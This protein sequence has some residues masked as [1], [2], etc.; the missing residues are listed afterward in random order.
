MSELDEIDRGIVRLMRD[1]GRISNTQIARLLN[2]SEGTIRTRLRRLEET[3]RFRLV[4]L[5]E[6]AAFGLNCMAH[7]LFAIEPRY[8]EP[9]A[10]FL[11]EQ[12]DFIFVS[13]TLSRYNVYG[14]C[15]SKD[16]ASL[17]R[18]ID[19]ELKTRK[20]FIGCKVYEASYSTRFDFHWTL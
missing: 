13:V 1:D 4:T 3:G 15:V 10:E 8:V 14:V 19:S 17:D 2:V 7:T 20:G 18:I 6:P 16:R 11:M 9:F 12:K 5:K